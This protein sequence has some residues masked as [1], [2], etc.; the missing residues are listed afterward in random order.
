MLT[1]G[2]DA[3]ILEGIN[4]RTII[5][6]AQKND[7]Q[8]VERPIDLTELYVADEVFVCG[9]SAFLSPVI[10]IDSRQVGQGDVT[11]R[12]QAAYRTS[13]LDPTSSYVTKL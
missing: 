13:L 7:I 6:L 12:L 3:D 11:K 9:T 2:R 1:P 4:R 5:E 10:E 8:V